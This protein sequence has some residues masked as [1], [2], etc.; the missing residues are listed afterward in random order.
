MYVLLC[1]FIA[2]SCFFAGILFCQRQINSAREKQ[3]AFYL[4]LLINYLNRFNQ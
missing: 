2:I 4:N 1:V 3:K